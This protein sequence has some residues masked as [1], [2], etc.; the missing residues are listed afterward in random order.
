M[1]NNKALFIFENHSSNEG[2]GLNW[3][4][5]ILSTQTAQ[6]WHITIS[7]E[8]VNVSSPLFSTVHDFPLSKSF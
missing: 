1:L 5:G 4:A 2:F 3:F 8:G 7:M 6:G